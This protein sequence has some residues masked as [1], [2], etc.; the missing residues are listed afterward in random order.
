MKTEQS[1]CYFKSEKNSKYTHE[2]LK[3]HDKTNDV[4][5]SLKKLK[6]TNEIRES[7][8]EVMKINKV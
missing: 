5:A 3:E 6:N 7:Y 8:E 2:M 1:M 4:C